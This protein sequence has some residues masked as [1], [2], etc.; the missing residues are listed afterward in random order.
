MQGDSR[1]IVLYIVIRCLFINLIIKNNI[2][3][4][5]FKIFFVIYIL[6]SF[7]GVNWL[8]SYLLPKW[9]DIL[10]GFPL[11]MY[12]IYKGMIYFNNIE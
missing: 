3:K 12:L 1:S 11:S 5:K 6:L 9:I 10:I 7:Y 2:M 8:A 4:L